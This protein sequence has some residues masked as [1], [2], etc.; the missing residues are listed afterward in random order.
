MGADSY[1]CEPMIGIPSN[2][3]YMGT[4]PHHNSMDTIDKVD[5]RTL[6]DM[7]VIC[8]AYL[9]Y[10]ADAGY[11]DIPVIANLTFNR[12]IKV[13][14]DKANGMHTRLRDVNEGVALGKILHDGSDRITYYTEQQIK[15]LNSIQRIIS[16]DKKGD[17]QKLLKP[18]IETIEGFG[19]TRVNLFRSMALEKSHNDSIDI[20]HSNLHKYDTLLFPQP[21]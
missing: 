15:A 8:A 7:S 14:L 1:Y 13:V 10:I 17:A 4:Y 5:P 6:H 20:R 19:R 9:Y 16:E 18:Y 3:V 12:G 21:R 2:V 11:D